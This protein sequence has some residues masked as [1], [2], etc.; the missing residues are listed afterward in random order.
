VTVNGDADLD[1]TFFEAG[2]SY[3]LSETRNFAMIAGLR[4]FT[5]GADIE[6]S[7]QA[8]SATPVDANRT[9]VNGV[10]G[11]TFGRRCRRR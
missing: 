5:M 10:A 6:F 1:N 11:F 7:T 2:G 8:I 9:A 4:T 3:L